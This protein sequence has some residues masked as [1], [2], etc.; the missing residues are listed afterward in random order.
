VA[1]RKLR[2]SALSFSTVERLPPP[3]IK[4]KVLLMCVTPIVFGMCVSRPSRDG[5]GIE[6]LS[7]SVWTA[8]SGSLPPGGESTGTVGNGPLTGS[9]IEVSGGMGT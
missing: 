4:R 3:G 8:C 2:A 1:A 6:A 7:S 5:I 9:A